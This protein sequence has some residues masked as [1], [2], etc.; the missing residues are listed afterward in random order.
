MIFRLLFK[1]CCRIE[2][3]NVCDEIL[4]VNL[5]CFHHNSIHHFDKWKYAVF[6]DSIIVSLTLNGFETKYFIRPDMLYILSLVIYE[7]F[8]GFK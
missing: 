7:G 3:F 1:A 6:C 2:V 5:K 8:M 4:M